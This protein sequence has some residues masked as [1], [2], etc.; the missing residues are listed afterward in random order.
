MDC[1]NIKDQLIDY[2][3]N[4]LNQEEKE[5]LQVHLDQCSACQK[6]FTELQS[7]LGIISNEP[8]EFPS[9]KLRSNFE[10]ALEIEKQQQTKVVKL[11]SRF[12]PDNSYEIC[13]RPGTINK[14]VFI[15]SLSTGSKV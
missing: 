4:N 6:E 13:C 11:K 8:L 1:K 5:K 12:K 10:Q 2:I 7:F 14:Y 9:D 15:R 3:E